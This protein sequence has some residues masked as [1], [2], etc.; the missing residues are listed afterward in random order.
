MLNGHLHLDFKQVIPLATAEEYQVRLRQKDADAREEAKQYTMR[1]RTL[2]AL[3]RKGAIQA[4]TEIE[5]VPEARPPDGAQRPANVFRARV[6]NPELRESIIW[7]QD[8][9]PYSLSNLSN[10]LSR[11]QG[12]KWFVSNT[13]KHWRVVGHERSMWDEAE[14]IRSES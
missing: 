14:E 3:V 10:K 1:E 5:V 8:N 12:F 6:G 4:G 9:Q 7:N 11:E 2:T 13:F